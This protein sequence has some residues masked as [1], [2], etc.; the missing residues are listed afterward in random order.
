MLASLKSRVEPYIRHYFAIEKA[1]PNAVARPGHEVDEAFEDLCKNRFE[2]DP[3]AVK[4]ELARIWIKYSA[5]GR[6]QKAL[7]KRNTLR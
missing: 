7:C 1:D 4:S 2:L 6:V 5:S 3:S